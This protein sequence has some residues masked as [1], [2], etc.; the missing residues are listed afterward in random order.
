MVDFKKFLEKGL[1]A[2]EKAEANKAEIDSVFEEL[3][4]QMDEA[5]NGKIYI[6]RVEFYVNSPIADL[7]S[8]ANLR[9]REKYTAIAAKNRTIQDCEYKQ[10]AK[11]KIDRNGYPCTIILDR[12]E[13]YCEDKTFLE[14]NLHR[15]LTDPV[16]C[17]QIYKLLSMVA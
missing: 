14:K 16:V 10:L 12:D 4:Q 2:A 15:L 8:L 6:S 7:A 3:N 5:T 13:M 11:W 17:D 1:S 9:P